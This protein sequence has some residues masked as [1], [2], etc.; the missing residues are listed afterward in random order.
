M[1]TLLISLTM[2]IGLVSGCGSAKETSK[3]ENSTTQPASEEAAPAPVV[4]AG[5]TEPETTSSNS[6]K[7]QQQD[8]QYR[9]VISFISIGEG[10]DPSARQKMDQLLSSWSQKAGKQ[11]EME[12]Y[13]WG[14]EGEV[15]FCFHLK[16][17]SG[18]DQ[19]IMVREIR[20]AFSGQP[21]IQIAEYQKSMNKR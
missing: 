5:G 3:N 11:I 6:N 13:P 8:V 16:E 7:D 9:L 15:D 19:A 10:T 21:L 17:L 4:S 20:E 1:K 2:I 18:P 14:R 12:T